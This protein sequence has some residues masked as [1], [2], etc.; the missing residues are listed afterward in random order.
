MSVAVPQSAPRGTLTFAQTCIPLVAAITL[1]LISE[2]IKE[3]SV[4]ATSVWFL[5]GGPIFCR[6]TVR[7]K[8]SDSSASLLIGMMDA[9]PEDA[10]KSTCGGYCEG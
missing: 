5:L 4:A 7:L 8:K 3:L 6:V 2:G 1:V 10:R 9:M